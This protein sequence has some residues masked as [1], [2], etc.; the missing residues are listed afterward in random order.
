[1]RYMMIVKSAN[2]GFGFPPKALIDEITKQAEE[3]VKTGKMLAVAASDQ[4]PR[5][6]GPAQQPESNGDRRAVHRGERN[7]W[8]IRNLNSSREK[9]R[10]P[11]RSNSWNC[12]ASTGLAGK[13]R[14]K[15]G[16]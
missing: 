7:H 5:G 8:G 6:T 4:R 14:R 13:A 10:L 2:E 3:A 12:I 16:R 9:S 15:C 1:M 11:R